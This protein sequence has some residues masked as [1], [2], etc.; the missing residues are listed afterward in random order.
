M[1]LVIVLDCKIKW[2]FSERIVLTV[3][4]NENLSSYVHKQPEHQ[5]QLLSTRLKLQMSCVDPR[6]WWTTMG[7][8]LLTLSP[9]QFNL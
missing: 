5:I 9:K 3:N 7:Q 2:C 4:D 8:A 1:A 6:P